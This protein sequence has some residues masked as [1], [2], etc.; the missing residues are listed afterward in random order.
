MKPN[1]FYRIPLTSLVNIPSDGD[2]EPTAVAAAKHFGRTMNPV[3][4]IKRGMNTETFEMMYEI[5]Y[6]NAVAE[7]AVLA[8]LEYVDAFVV[9]V[10]DELTAKD[11]FF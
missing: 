5:V 4:V 8:G 2:T 7:V 3:I 9:D 11:L 6:N 10:K 1:E